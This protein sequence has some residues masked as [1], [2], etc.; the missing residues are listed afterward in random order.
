MPLRV[1]NFCYSGSSS[2][3]QES[4]ATGRSGSVGS[5]STMS[6]SSATSGWKTSLSVAYDC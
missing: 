3:C 4:D 6:E 1:P 5:V 2:S